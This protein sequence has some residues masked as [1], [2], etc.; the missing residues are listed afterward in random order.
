MYIH[1]H[2]NPKQLHM[3]NF[4]MVEREMWR[5]FNCQPCSLSFPPY[6]FPPFYCPS[7]VP[8]PEGSTVSS[9]NR[10]RWSIASL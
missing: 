1:H 9:S 7:L 2:L 10:S 3:K 5:G 4:A 8:M 6:S